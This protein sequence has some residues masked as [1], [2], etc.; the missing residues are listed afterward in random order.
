MNIE[1]KAR[2]LNGDIVARTVYRIDDNMC[3][4]PSLG[5]IHNLAQSYRNEV[6]D[7]RY[8]DG[9]KVY[10]YI[11]C[12]TDDSVS[13]RCDERPHDLLRHYVSDKTLVK[14]GTS[15]GSDD[16]ESECYGPPQAGV[17]SPAGATTATSTPSASS[18]LERRS[19][20]GE[21]TVAPPRTGGPALESTG[22]GAAGPSQAGGQQRGKSE[23]A[24]ETEASRDVL[25]TTPSP[26]EDRLQQQ[27]KP[28]F[29]AVPQV[30]YLPERD[31]AELVA[32]HFKQDPKAKTMAN[33]LACNVDD[34]TGQGAKEVMDGLGRLG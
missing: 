30:N 31:C 22:R 20:K 32:A 3:V 17:A 2:S 8:V 24:R 19:D 28:P 15:G 26:G 13:I 10:A 14:D 21:T 25:V 29:S 6:F 18:G 33:K 12:P 1:I 27:Q 34:L 7:G 11:K 16:E 23:P 9:E 4:D 5:S